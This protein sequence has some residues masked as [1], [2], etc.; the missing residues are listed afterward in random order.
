MVWLEGL[1]ELWNWAG[2]AS[3]E[4]SAFPPKQSPAALTHL[5]LTPTL[6]VAGARHSGA[7]RGVPPP[8]APDGGARHRGARRGGGAV[9]A[10]E[11]GGPGACTLSFAVSS[12]CLSL[13]VCLGGGS[14]WQ[15]HG[16]RRSVCSCTGRAWWNCV[17][18]V[19]ERGQV[20]GS[21]LTL[22]KLTSF[23]PPPHLCPAVLT[24]RCTASAPRT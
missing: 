17:R 19:G 20:A 18:G 4:R 9:R 7:Q 2:C 5:P 12:V 13:S 8:A 21:T 24:Y 22:N 11:Q 23:L 1:A 6:P 16:R 10:A 14:W 15:M 3:S